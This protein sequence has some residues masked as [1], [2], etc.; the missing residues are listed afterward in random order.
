LFALVFSL[1]VSMHGP[2]LFISQLQW[3]QLS[4]DKMQWVGGKDIKSWNWVQPMLGPWL[5]SKT[6]AQ[7]G[8]DLLQSLSSQRFW[9]LL[10]RSSI[11]HSPLPHFHWSKQIMV[12]FLLTSLDLQR[13]DTRGGPGLGWQMTWGWVACRRVQRALD[14]YQMKVSLDE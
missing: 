14:H 3:V 10:P 11:S 9:G 4:A 1:A 8:C 7:E 13:R 12:V 6:R 2:F 5:L